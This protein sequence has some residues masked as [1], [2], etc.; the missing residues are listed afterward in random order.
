MV[1]GAS[2]SFFLSHVK[3]W[4]WGAPLLVL[5]L[6]IDVAAKYAESLLAVKYPDVDRH[7]EMSGSF[8]STIEKEK[9]GYF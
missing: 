7:G 6:L 8:M 4:V 9:N 1:Y 5:L 3:D 2:R